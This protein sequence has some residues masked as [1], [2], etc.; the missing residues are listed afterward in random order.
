MKMEELQH[1]QSN[2]GKGSVH[3]WVAKHPDENATCIV[4]TH[5]MT[6]DHSMFAPQIEHFTQNYTVI[7]W[8]MPLHGQS[9]PYQGFSYR[10]TAAELR[11]ILTQEGIHRVVLVGMSMG[12]HPSQMFAHLYPELVAGLIALD[13]LPLGPQ[14]YTKFSMAAITKLPT[15]LKWLPEK[16]IK[17]NMVKSICHTEETRAITQKLLAPLTKAEILNQLSALFKAFLMENCKVNLTCPGLILLGEFDTIAGIQGTCAIWA[18]N[19]GYPLQIIKNAGH[20]SSGDNA[21]QVNEAIARFIEADCERYC[22][23]NE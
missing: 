1:R 21:P 4:F 3:Y 22:F 18:K 17:K 14:Y 2:T 11:A 5:G 7:A 12:G 13:T 16:E 9:M 20:F 19:T 15:L 10:Q 6:A 8:D 23:Y